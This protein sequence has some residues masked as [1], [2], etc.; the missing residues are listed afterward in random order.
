MKNRFRIGTG[1]LE[2]IVLLETSKTLGKSYEVFKLVFA[3]GE[4]DMVIFDNCFRV[5]EDKPACVIV[6]SNI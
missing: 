5:L 6:G 3:G 2:D 4:F 1:M